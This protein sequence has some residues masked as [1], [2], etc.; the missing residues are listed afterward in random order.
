MNI[1][2][3]LLATLIFISIILLSILFVVVQWGL[4]K[5][6]L[7][8]VN[9]KE[10]QSLQLLSSNLGK[11]YQQTGSWDRIKLNINAPAYKGPRR[12]PVPDSVWIQMILLSN[13]LNIFPKDVIGYLKEHQPTN[14][15]KRPPPPHRSPPPEPRRKPFKGEGEPPHP[16]MYAGQ[17]SALL[18]DLLDMNKNIIIGRSKKRRLT[19]EIK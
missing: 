18:P 15:F 13:E 5:G 12:P 11:Y 1:F 14:N 10:L 17:S 7:E 19:K 2:S 4:T 6:M 8:Y 16:E 3:K 9:N